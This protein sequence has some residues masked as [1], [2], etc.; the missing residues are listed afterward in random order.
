[1]NDVI[2]LIKKYTPLSY[3]AEQ[4]VAEAM[5][6]QKIERGEYLL[7]EG[8]RCSDLWFIRSGMLRSYYLSDGKEVT[9]WIHFEGEIITALMSFFRQTPSSHYITTCE[10]T[11]LL[12]LS[13]TDREL[14]TDKFPE[15]ERF[16]RLIMEEQVCMLDEMNKRFNLLPAKEKYDTLR[17]ISPKM[18]QRAQLKHIASI[19]GITPETLSRIR[20]G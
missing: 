6:P 10:D 8:E 19:M 1:M 4:A 9:K 11:E 17:A 20:K 13:Y 2:K 12:A 3:E 5:S 7:R 18:V 16:G 14:L 15:I